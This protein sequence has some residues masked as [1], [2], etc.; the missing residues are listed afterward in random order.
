MQVEYAEISLIGSRSE[1]Q[2]RIASIVNSDA[3]L[4]AA[5]DGMGGHA[6]GAQAAEL[7]RRTVLARF[8]AAPHPLTDPLAF[9]HISMGAAHTE[10]VA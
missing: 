10:M 5:F 9:L 7:A 1:N 6:D 2:D 8:A 3:A 4:I